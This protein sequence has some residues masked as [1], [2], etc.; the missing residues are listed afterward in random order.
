LPQDPALKTIKM[1]QGDI[2]VRTRAHLMAMLWWD[3]RDICML[4]NIHEVA[5]KGNFCNVGRKAM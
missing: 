2:H 1:K 3:K 4:M 5:E